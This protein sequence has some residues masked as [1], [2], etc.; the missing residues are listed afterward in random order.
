LARL[1]PP[2]GDEG[3]DAGGGDGADL[4]GLGEPLEVPQRG[5]YFV[6]GADGHAG[7]DLGVI[8]LAELGPG[9]A[10]VALVGAGVQLVLKPVAKRLGVTLSL[11]AGSAALAL[12]LTLRV[13]PAD[14]PAGFVGA[15]LLHLLVVLVNPHLRHDDAPFENGRAAGVVLDTH[16]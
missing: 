4:A 7:E 6:L 2:G 3:V 15:V 1:L 10:A 11:A 9:R 5:L 13:D 8:L 16:G 12:P 14:V